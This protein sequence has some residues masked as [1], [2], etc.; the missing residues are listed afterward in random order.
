MLEMKT[1]QNRQ[2]REYCDSKTLTVCEQI[3]TSAHFHVFNWNR[4]D[5]FSTSSLSSTRSAIDNA[6]YQNWFNELKR[7]Q[8]PGW[9]QLAVF[10]CDKMTFGRNEW[11]ELSLRGSEVRLC[12]NKM[13]RWGLGERLSAGLMG[14]LWAEFKK[15]RSTPLMKNS[16]ITLTFNICVLQ[17]CVSN[18]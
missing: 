12:W 4:D 6:K 8:W 16:L 15:R 13:W 11:G 10:V 7:A 14:K 5:M 3:H 9:K 2:N 1:P 17:P 18:L